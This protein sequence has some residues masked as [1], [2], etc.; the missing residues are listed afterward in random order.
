M[1][2]HG[3]PHRRIGKII[4]ATAPAEGEH[5]RIAAAAAENGVDDLA[6]LDAADL[7]RLEPAL[8]GVAGLLSPSTGI[9]DSHALML[10]L[11]G[12]AEDHGAAVALRT[13][14]VGAAPAPAP[15]GGFVVEAEGEAGGSGSAPG[16]S[17]TPPGSGPGVATAIEGLAAPHRRE[18]S[19]A[20]APT[21]PLAARV[22]S[23]TSLYPVPERDGLGSTSPSTLPA[24]P[25]SGRTPSGSPGIDYGLDPPRGDGSTRRSGATGRGSPTG[26]SSRGYTGIRP[27][28]APAGGP[29]TDFLIEGPEVHGLPG[30][31]NLFGIES[32]GLTASLAI[33]G[34]VLALAGVP[35]AA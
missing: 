2:G 18:S 8:A 4:V 5:S 15:G 13:A 30:L 14:F 20:R 24:R 1:R 10:S 6:P 12:E 25:A 34:E 21:S 11:L 26:R 17:S 22:P 33:A 32:P 19:S 16:S 35:A 23:R 27:K 7:G 9:I 31:V 3:V 28:L 29:A